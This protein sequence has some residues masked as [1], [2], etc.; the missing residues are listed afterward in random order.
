VTNIKQ[1][2]KINDGDNLRRLHVVIE[3]GHKNEC[4]LYGLNWKLAYSLSVE[5]KHLKWDFKWRLV[6]D[7]A[8]WNS[9]WI[10]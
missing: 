9:M 3:R 5:N 2:R 10:G 1:R 4:K 8:K 7:V 6:V